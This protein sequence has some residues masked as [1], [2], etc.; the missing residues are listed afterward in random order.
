MYLGVFFIFGSLAILVAFMQPRP[1]GWPGGLALVFFG[2]TLSVGWAHAFA[3][4]R[5]WLLVPLLVVPFYAEPLF[6]GPLSRLGLF[7][8]GMGASE[9]VRKV[10][11]AVMMVVLTSIGFVIFIQ[12]VRGKERRAERAQ[13]ELDVARVIHESI[14]PPIALSTPFAQV[15]ARSVPSTEMG[16]DL[17]DTMQRD[18][19]IDVF[20]ADV[21][22]HGVG[23]GI[24]MGMLK[25][26]IRTRLLAAGD[27]LGHVLRDVNR[28]TTDLT[29]PEMFATL[30]CARVRADRSVSY[31]L[32]GHL[33]IFH[34]VASEQR[35]NRLENEHLPLGIDADVDFTSGTLTAGPG[36]LLVFLTDGLVEVMNAKGDQLGLEAISRVLESAT[37]STPQ[38]ITDALLQAARSHGT[39]NDDQSVL[40]VRVA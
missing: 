38:A 20:L 23:A 36:D 5:F 6:F 1:M 11:L 31:A 27:D 24:V 16:G 29:R 18:R 37:E 26:S 9:L 10:T 22:G 35:W 15:L 14:V 17:V 25:A 8:V 32:A 30:A 19:E 4:R 34:F 33:P 12:F 40:V 39:Q 7:G 13:A 21:S 28:V 3:A 2:G